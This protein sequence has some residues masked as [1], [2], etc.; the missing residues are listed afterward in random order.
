MTISHYPVHMDC[1]PAVSGEAIWHA[2][3]AARRHPLPDPATYPRELLVAE[4]G[5]DPVQLAYDSAPCEVESLTG[6][7]FLRVL[8]LV[9]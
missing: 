7:A 1:S 5:I 9:V 8:E 4:A 6:S 2:L 3:P